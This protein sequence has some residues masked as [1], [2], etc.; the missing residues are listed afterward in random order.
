M[1]WSCWVKG[2]GSC[3]AGVWGSGG[4]CMGPTYTSLPFTPTDALPEH[5]HAAAGPG[6]G[7]GCACR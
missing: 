3:S 2:Q 1:T 6:P 4:P 7:P 5:A